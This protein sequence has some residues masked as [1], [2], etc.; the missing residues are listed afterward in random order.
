MCLASKQT[1]ICSTKQIALHY[2][3][4]LSTESRLKS[5]LLRA[6]LPAI[7]KLKISAV[8]CLVLMKNCAELTIISQNKKTQ[9]ELHHLNHLSNVCSNTSKN[10]MHDTRTTFKLKLGALKNLK[11]AESVLK[12]RP[13][14][15]IKWN[16]S[17]KRW[18][19]CTQIKLESSRREKKTPW[20]GFVPVKLSQRNLLTLIAREFSKEKRP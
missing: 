7:V 19:P 11:S 4:T 13:G 14:I 16:P 1:N 2:S 3:M 12:R 15:E 18:R 6:R 9:N 5:R 20:K 8:I 17:D 10:V